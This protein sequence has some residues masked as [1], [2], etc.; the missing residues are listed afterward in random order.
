MEWKK[1]R[2]KIAGTESVFQDLSL[3]L[4]LSAHWLPS[5]ICSVFFPLLLNFVHKV[6][7]SSLCLECTFPDL[8]IAHIIQ[9]F[10]QMRKNHAYI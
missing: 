7:C 9:Y 1:K 3:S 6:F 10:L 4:S 2:E 5:E 8:H